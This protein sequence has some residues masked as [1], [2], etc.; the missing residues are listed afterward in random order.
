MNAHAV[1][2]GA[3][4]AAV[5]IVV[6]A[7]VTDLGLRDRLHGDPLIDRQTREDSLATAGPKHSKFV[8]DRGGT[9]AEVGFGRPSRQVATAP[10]HL[11]LLGPTAGRDLDAGADTVA[12]H[13]AAA[14]EIDL[15][16]VAAR[17]GRRVVAQEERRGVDVGDEQIL[18]AVEIGI[19]GD[20]GLRVARR[21]QLFREVTGSVVEEQ[22]VRAIQEARQLLPRVDDLDPLVEAIDDENVGEPVVV[23]I[24]PLDPPGPSRVVHATRLGLIGEGDPPRLGQLVDEQGVAAEC[25][26]RIRDVVA[27]QIEVPVLV[28]VGGR[29]AHVRADV[30]GPGQGRPVDE[31][32]VVVAEVEVRVAV[33]REVQIRI[34]IV[35]EVGEDRGVAVALDRSQTGRHGDVLE[36][37]ASEVTE[38][39]VMPRHVRELPMLKRAPVGHVDVEQTVLIVVRN[40]EPAL[41]VTGRREARACRDVREHAGTIVFVDRGG[42]VQPRIIRVVDQ[43]QIRVAVVVEVDKH[44]HA[45]HTEVL[46]ACRDRIVDEAQGAGLDQ[47]VAVQDVPMTVLAQHVDVEVA[48]AVIV[49][50]RS[51]VTRVALDH[52]QHYLGLRRDPRRK[53]QARAVLVKKIDPDL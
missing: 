48:V 36:L 40:A 14:V 21:S 26:Q 24:E 23:G 30:V 10:D 32:P 39:P 2:V 3:V 11:L 41:D 4:A 28:E 33:H 22:V 50:D 37:K 7:I 43:N 19:E 49:L 45:A 9:Q 13:H 25:P 34:V 5:E 46:E 12:V 16:P 47:H 29:H 15:Q 38:Q 1:G 53:R 6:D 52:V 35:V 42:G 8:H 17:R 31:D 27:V 51:P 20:R 44:R 18:I